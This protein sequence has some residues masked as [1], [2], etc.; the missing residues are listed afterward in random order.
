[1]GHQNGARGRA[2][3]SGIGIP[4][5]GLGTVEAR[6]PQ[7]EDHRRSK[8]I[9]ILRAVAV[10]LVFGRHMTPCPESVSPTLHALTS[11]WHQ[12]GWVGVDLFF[13]LSG[14]LVSGLLFQEHEKYGRISG[15][16]FLVR[17]GFKIYPGFWVLTLARVAVDR[18]RHNQRPGGQ[19]AAEVLFFQN[20]QH[21]M[22]WHT[23]SLAVEEHFYLLLVILL[24]VLSS[25][26]RVHP[27]ATIPGIFVAVSVLC[28]GLRLVTPYYPFDEYRSLYPTHLRIDSL[29]FGVFLSY[30]AHF[31]RAGFVSVTRRY[32]I[33]L[34]CAGAL[35]FLPA[36][37]L[38][39]DNSRLLNT[40]G[41][42]LFYI[43]GGCLLM[44]ALS[45]DIPERGIAAAM[46]FVGSRSYS[47]Y[48]WHVTVLRWGVP[49]LA[50]ISAYAA[51]WPVYFPLYICGA[52]IL[53]IV[54][55]ALVEYPALRLRDRLFPSR[56]Q[57]L[58]GLP[59]RAA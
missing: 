13:V 47:I 8:A 48:L 15:G 45:F 20:Y 41:L 9:D 23:W 34:L 10:L 18:L 54:M 25:R 39:L 11:V 46:A 50:A 53:G 19:L 26:R 16:R 33:A 31:H 17:R 6:A 55:A 21:G 30:I 57:A 3:S 52:L 24:V 14:F 51:Y 5:S 36:F 37:V 12:G 49:L 28:L 42:T 1:M 22:W 44:G 38:P 35:L 43:A 4:D 40:F 27:F 58:I 59:A 56:G 2:A 29:F 7:R 32:R